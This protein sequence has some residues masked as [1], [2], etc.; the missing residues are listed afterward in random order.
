MPKHFSTKPISDKKYIGALYYPC[1]IDIS[2]LNA[3]RLAARFLTFGKCV[4][5]GAESPLARCNERDVSGG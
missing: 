1:T 5:L 2:Y 3:G 4:R